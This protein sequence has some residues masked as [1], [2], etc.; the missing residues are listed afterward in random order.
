[1]ALSIATSDGNSLNTESDPERQGS[2][3]YPGN[4]TKLKG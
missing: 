1:M 4:V 3:E 2:C